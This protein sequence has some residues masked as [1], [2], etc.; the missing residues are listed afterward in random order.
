MYK[1]IFLI[2]LLHILNDT[3]YYYKVVTS[4]GDET[5]CKYTEKEY[6]EIQHIMR[7]E[8]YGNY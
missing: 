6:R 7:L 2:E 5:L 3:D 1:G 8:R 4:G